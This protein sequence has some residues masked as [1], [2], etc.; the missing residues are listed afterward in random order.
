MYL[1]NSWSYS[2]LVNSGQFIH[3]PLLP[4]FYGVEIPL[5][6]NPF[7]YLGMNTCKTTIS[8]TTF[9]SDFDSL[10][11]RASPAEAVCHVTRIPIQGARSP[12]RAH[13]PIRRNRLDCSIFHW[14][15]VS[16]I[17]RANQLVPEANACWRNKTKKK[18]KKK[19]M[20]RSLACLI[21]AGSWIETIGGWNILSIKP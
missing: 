9:P 6:R 13:Q 14:S 18:K 3:A 16:G 5:G 15:S 4:Q 19:Q 12:P 7:I 17:N 10:A 11:K 20:C 1:V 21:L 8:L 2:P